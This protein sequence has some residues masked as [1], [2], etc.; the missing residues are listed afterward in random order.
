MID[1]KRFVDRIARAYYCNT[2]VL[3][4]DAWDKLS[5]AAKSFW[6]NE[7]EM[8]IDATDRARI[9]LYDCDDVR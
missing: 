8:F 9:C 4:N 1:D 7:I 6:I 2:L 3:D 5:D